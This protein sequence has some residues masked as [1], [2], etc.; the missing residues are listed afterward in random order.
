MLF[1]SQIAV[2]GLNGANG[3]LKLRIDPTPQPPPPPND[4]F[5]NRI[6]IAALPALVFG[7]NTNASREPGELAFGPSASGSTVW[8]RWRAAANGPVAVSTA[9]AAFDT[10]IAVF[11][12]SA[13]TNLQPV[14]VAS[15]FACCSQARVIFDAVGGRDYAIGVDGLNGQ[16]GAITLNLNAA[17]RPPN[18]RFVDRLH[19]AGS[20][21]FTTANNADASADPDD[22]TPFSGLSRKSLWWDWTAPATARYS[23][24]LQGSS[25]NAA[26]AVYLGNSPG[27]LVLEEKAVGDACCSPARTALDAFANVRYFLFVDGINGSAGPISLSISN[28]PPPVNDNFSLRSPLVEIGRAHV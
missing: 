11:T 5:T 18:D 13:A 24:S 9:G 15:G 28:A 3:L 10:F 17:A 6:E 12:G 26:L 7:A 4:A 25:I 19:L 23:I 27:N 14:A 22:P 2:D 1:R 20:H 21:A 16:E 8:W